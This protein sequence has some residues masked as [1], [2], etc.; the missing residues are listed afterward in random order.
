MT[1][2]LGIDPHRI[3]LVLAGPS[4]PRQTAAELRKEDTDSRVEVHIVDRAPTDAARG[5][6]ESGK[7]SSEESDGWK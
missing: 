2:T 5:A 1:E 6:D 7:E 4:E 3:V